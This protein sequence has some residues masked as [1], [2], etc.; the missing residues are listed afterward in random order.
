MAKQKKKAATAFALFNVVYEDGTLASNRRV[1]DEVLDDLY[2]DNPAHTFLEA[3]DRRI[4][5][6]SGVSKP[7]IKSV[8]RVK[9][10]KA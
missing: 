8:T 6:Q 7:R 3:Q 2:D 10:G 4:A 9:S 5:E 1:P